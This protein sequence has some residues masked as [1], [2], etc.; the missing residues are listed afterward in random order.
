MSAPGG[1]SVED[2]DGNPVVG[3]LLF[4]GLLGAAVAV[5]LVGR[6]VVTWYWKVNEAITTME[7]MEAVLR[8]IDKN[9]VVLT[10]NSERTPDRGAQS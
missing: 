9:L 3:V 8:N 6:E 7:R 5:L 10:D 4:V 1:G 2:M